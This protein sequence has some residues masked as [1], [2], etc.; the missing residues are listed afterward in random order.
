MQ[1]QSQ[2]DSHKF[3]TVFFVAAVLVLILGVSSFINQENRLSAEQS[4]Q[5]AADNRANL[6]A[7]LN[8]AKPQYSQQDMTTM[9]LYAPQSYQAI[10][11]AQQ[12][13]EAA[14]Y[15]QYRTN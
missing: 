5:A 11:Q 10:L 6:A 7:C 15:Q 14:C 4:A 8:S 13:A 12:T 9:A 2:T 1:D 3:V